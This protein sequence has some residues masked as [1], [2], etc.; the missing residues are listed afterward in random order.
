[1]YGYCRV[2]TTVQ[3]IDSQVRALRDEG[4]S[5]DNVYVDSGV[6]G[7]LSD[8]P[9]LNDLL[10]RLQSGDEVVT[11]KLDRMFRSLGHAVTQMEEWVEQG[12]TF[13]ALGDGIDTTDQTPAGKAMR[14]MLAVFAEMERDFNRER[15]KAGI[16]AARARGKQIG[17][18]KK[19]NP[20]S[21]ELAAML[22]SKGQPIAKIARTLKMSRATVYRMLGELE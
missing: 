21:A 13:R 12:I 9:A 16:E 18:P 1:M 20:E 7:S 2:S 5:D 11:L 8:R 10:K 19:R 6:S 22:R 14:H 17:R 3:R 15:T 4:I